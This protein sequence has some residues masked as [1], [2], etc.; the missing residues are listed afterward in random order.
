VAQEREKRIVLIVSPEEARE[1]RVKAANLG[2]S[3]YKMGREVLLAFAR[4]QLVRAPR[5][6]GI[7]ADLP[8]W[9]M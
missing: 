6:P 1:M 4:G 2:L 5:L 9:L 8:D 3:T 7:D